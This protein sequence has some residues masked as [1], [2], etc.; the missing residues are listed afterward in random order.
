[1][2]NISKTFKMTFS[3]FIG[4]VKD[5]SPPNNNIMLKGLWYDKKG[6]WNKAHELIDGFP[7]DDAAWIHA[8]LHRKE[9]DLWN[10]K[11]WY[12]RANRD[13]PDSTLDQEWEELVR[14]FL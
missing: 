14:Y 1:L 9:G 13:M 11:Y 6:N 12:S 10:A 4:S 7:G 5:G 3:E 2:S 8:Y